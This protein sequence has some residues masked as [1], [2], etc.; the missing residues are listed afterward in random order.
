MSSKKLCRDDGFLV[1]LDDGETYSSEGGD[2]AVLR[3]DWTECTFE[4]DMKCWCYVDEDN[5]EQLAFQSGIKEVL[6]LTS[7]NLLKIKKK[8]PELWEAW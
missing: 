4:G 8:L 5:E 1:F 6:R 2:C 3:G 7:S